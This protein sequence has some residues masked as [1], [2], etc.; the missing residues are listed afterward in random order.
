MD[1]ITIFFSILADECLGSSG[2]EQLSLVLRF[3]NSA[4]KICEELN[5]AV[6]KGFQITSVNNILE[7]VHKISFG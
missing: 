7:T 5:L 2:K 6:V 3:V 1:Q 4:H